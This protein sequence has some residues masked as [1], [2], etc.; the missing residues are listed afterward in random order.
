MKLYTFYTPSHEELINKYFLPSLSNNKEFDIIIKQFPQLCSDGEFMHNGWINTMMQ[1]VEYHIQ[2]CLENHNDIFV[3]S[4]CDVQFLNNEQV[5]ETLLNELEDYD[6][7]CQNDVHP[8]FDRTTYCAGFFICR[9]NNKTVNLFT[10]V[11]EEMKKRYPS[12]HDQEALNKNL[13]TVK[14]KILSNQF[15]THAQTLKKL[16][17]NENDT[18][19]IPK[20]IMVHHANWTH[21]IKNKIKLLDIVKEQYEYINNG[22]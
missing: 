20:N 7:A 1:K 2:S 18:F 17:E 22:A 21:G 9:G 5:V 12:M 14:H 15:Y 4:D 3:Y 6:I 10:S 13:N 19:S 11:L 8:Y 16:W